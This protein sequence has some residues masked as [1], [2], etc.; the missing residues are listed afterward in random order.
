[1]PVCFAAATVTKKESEP[2]GTKKI[3]EKKGKG[4]KK[5]KYRSDG[6]GY[7]IKT[8]V[9]DAAPGEY[10]A[11]IKR[12]EMRPDKNQDPRMDISWQISEAVTES[13]ECAKSEKSFVTDRIS[14]LPLSA[15][16]RGNIHKQQLRK[17]CSHLNVDIDLVPT[18]QDGANDEDFDELIEALKEAGQDVT[19]WVTHRES[20][21]EGGEKQ[22]WVDV[23]YTA[24]RS[25]AA[26]KA[27]DEDE[28]EEEESDDDE[29]EDE[30]EKP[31]KKSKA[32]AKD[33]D[34]EEEDDEDEEE[35]E[36]ED[37]DDDDDDDEEEEERSSK[38]KKKSKR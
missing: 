33:E 7:S 35:D 6:S 20:E 25:T 24:P 17:L 21:G 23:K 11:S 4:E 26:S 3:E 19:I 27:K 2:M 38:K 10:I 34:E 9:P 16:R 13:D 1:M 12:I 18:L 32:K 36:D 37:D 28:D 31:R 5:Y 14:F 29:D 15:G 8:M 22:T 30:D